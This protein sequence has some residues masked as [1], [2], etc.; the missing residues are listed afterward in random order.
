MVCIKARHDVA[1]QESQ[2]EEQPLGGY[3]RADLMPGHRAP[4]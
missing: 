3:N 2:A 4:K 1:L